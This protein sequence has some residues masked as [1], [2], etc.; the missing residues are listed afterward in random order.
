MKIFHL[1]EEK[2]LQLNQR[3]EQR[4]KERTAELETANKDLAE[5]NDLFVGREARII[6][7]KEELENLNKK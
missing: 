6:E 2:I 5:I 4:V 1:A 3:L 7:L